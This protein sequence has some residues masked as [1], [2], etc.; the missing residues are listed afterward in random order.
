MKKLYP[1]G[2]TLIEVLISLIIFSIGTLGLGKFQGFIL[3]S[4]SLA[5]QRT[6]AL[7]EAKN[8]I[9]SLKLGNNKTSTGER[10]TQGSNTVFTTNWELSP[11]ENSGTILDATISWPDRNNVGE[12]NQPKASHHTTIH[13]KSIIPTQSYAEDSLNFKIANTNYVSLRQFNDENMSVENEIN[14][15]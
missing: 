3:Q 1:K 7:L 15:N 6:E 10:Q 9:E 13:F 2:S 4:T 5:K 14:N 12:K 11:K 8:I